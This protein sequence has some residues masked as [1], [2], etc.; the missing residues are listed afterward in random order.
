MYCNQCGAFIEDSNSAFCHNCGS[1]LASSANNS[2]NN[3]YQNKFQESYQNNY[4]QNFN[5]QPPAAYGQLPTAYEIDNMQQDAP[6]QQESSNRKAIIIACSVVGAIAVICAIVVGVFFLVKG[7]VIPAGE[8]AF[9]YNEDYINPDYKDLK[10]GMIVRVMDVPD[11]DYVDMKDYPSLDSEFMIRINEDELVDILQ[12]YNSKNNEYIFARYLEDGIYY[13]G[14]VPAPYLKYESMTD[15]YKT[16]KEGMRCRVMEDIP[17][18]DGLALRKSPSKD[19][20]SIETVPESDYVDVLEDYNEKNGKYVYVRYRED[21]DSYEGWVLGQ[22]IYFVSWNEDYENDDSNVKIVTFNNDYSDFVAGA[23]CEIGNNTPNHGGVTMRSRAVY[24]S[25]EVTSIREGQHIV[26]LS[27]YRAG[28]NG[29]VYSFYAKGDETYRGWISAKY[30]RYVSKVDGDYVNYL[31]MLFGEEEI[32]EEKTTREAEEERDK[33][34]YMDYERGY[35]C[36]I[37]DDTPEHAGL[38]LREGPSKNT[39]LVGPNPVD[40]GTEVL[41]LEDYSSDDG[42]YLKVFCDGYIGYLFGEYLIYDYSVYDLYEYDDYADYMQQNEE[43]EYV[44]DDTEDDTW[45]NSDVNEDNYDDTGDDSNDFSDETEAWE[46][47]S[48]DDTGY[49]DQNN[50]N[51]D[52]FYDETTTAEAEPEQTDVSDAHMSFKNGDTVYVGNDTVNGDGLTLRSAGSKES[53]MVRNDP[54]E[55]GTMLTVIKDY[56]SSDDGYIQVS[57]TDDL[58]SF[59]GYLKGKYLV[60]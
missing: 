14:W 3:N 29:Y 33:D 54:V 32:E 2:T 36:Y 60:Y 9:S 59:T 42:V 39:D 31:D 58:G 17:D 20:D 8:N 56:S 52:D 6:A 15:D 43:S 27:D 47:D 1:Q 28:D 23:I 45:D 50:S 46:D 55:E 10:A 26:I 12:D 37:S 18:Y 34:A 49:D 16:L 19:A 48:D 11:A 22:Y 30:L 38:N 41:V 35:V 7:P 21:G 4:Q 53:D 44:E 5:A 57:F 25:K 24:G 13:D 40:E 51:S